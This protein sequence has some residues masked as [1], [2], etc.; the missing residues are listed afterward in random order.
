MNSLY[1][2]DSYL[3]EAVTNIEQQRVVKKKTA[4]TLVDDIFYPSGGGQ[5]FDLGLL[6]VG[7]RKYNV[8]R[9]VKI[10]GKNWLCLDTSDNIAPDTKV[11]AII[12]WERRYR[13]MRCHTAAHVVMGSIRRNVKNYI[14]EG[15]E[16]SEDFSITLKFS[17]EWNATPENADK[18]ITTANNVIS[19]NR[20]VISES[21][22]DVKEAVNKYADIFR[23]SQDFTG[24]VRI[25]VIEN[26]DAN[27][28]GGTHIL[29]LD[30]IGKVKLIEFTSDSFTLRLED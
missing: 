7:E 2:K 10:D 21:F 3:K 15:I 23:G 22:D 14:P 25:T 12:N 17:G 9:I 11:T 8:T 19:E 4:V 26:W 30:E 29:R 20:N 16:I 18:I 6:V 27:P 5:P 1:Q 24:Q 28:C 13:F